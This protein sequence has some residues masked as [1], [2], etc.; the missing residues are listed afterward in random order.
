MTTLIYLHEDA[1]RKTHPIFS[2]DTDVYVFFI[3]DYRY[4]KNTDYGYNRLQFIY[5][6][7]SSLPFD[8][9]D[10]DTVDVI[11]TLID[12]YE[13][14]KLLIPQTPN[15]LIKDNMNALTHKIK[16]NYIN[17]DPFIKHSSHIVEKRFFKFWNKIKNK[18]FTHNG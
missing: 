10:G 1:C 17:D 3:W 8:I 6:A 15:G 13:A 5:E 4:F 11:S 16:I 14:K 18:A 7:M 2:I 9:Y 12:Q